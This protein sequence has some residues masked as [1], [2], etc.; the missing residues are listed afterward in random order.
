MKHPR[1][2][3]WAFTLV[4]V[5]VIVAVVSILSTV[6]YV[7]ITG[8]REGSAASKLDQDVAVLNNAI[9]AYLASGGN[10]DNVTTAA[11][12]LA[13]LKTRATA[14]SA[15]QTLGATGSFVDPRI[16]PVWQDAAEA[17][18]PVLRAY[19]TASPTPRFY[20]SAAAGAAGIKQFALD[21]A[22]AAG[23]P[24]T[25]TRD[26]TLAQ[27]TVSGW[28]WAYED[29]AAPEQ[30]PAAVPVAEDH[31]TVLNPGTALVTLDPPVISPAAGSRTI[32]EY[33]LTL[34]ISNPNDAGS[35]VIYY[36]LGSGP[37]VLFSA[38]FT[39]GPTQVTAVCVSLD[40]SRYADSAPASAT[41]DVTPVQLALQVSAPASLTYAQAGG[42]MIGEAIQS[43]APATINLVTA[44]PSAYLS[45]ANFQ[46][47]YTTDGSDP[48]TSGTAVTGSPFSG[49]FAPVP[50]NIALS[51]TA[52]W[53]GSSSLTLR[54]A[55]RSL[56]ADYFTSSGV[57]EATVS[58][59]PVALPAPT[60]SPTNQ[61]VTATVTVVIS[62]P[63]TG[64]ATNLVI[65]YT[66]NGVS[67]TVTNS[68]VYGGPF[69]FTAFT[70]NEER[71]AMA[72]SFPPSGFL[73]NWFTASGPA[74]RTYV[75]AASIGGF[76]SGAL[77][78]SATLNSTFNGNITIAYPTNGAVADITYNQNA[79]INGSLYVPGTPRVAQ[80][81]PYIPQWTTTNDSQFANRIYGIVEGQSPSPRVVDLTG[82]TL[83]TNY[84]ITFNN[85]SY[86]TGKIFRRIERY[87]L[88][89]LDVSTFPPKT[90]SASLSLNGPVSAP[91]NPANV[92][93]VTL[94]TTAVGSVPLL[95]GTYGNM[96]A[97]NNSKFVLGNAAD[98]DTPVVYNF[99]SLTLNSGADLVIVGKVIL[100][101]KGGFNLSNGAVVG[102]INNPDWLQI[103]VW[104]ANVNVASGSS[105]YGRIF[106][107]NNTIAFNN[108]SVLNGSVSAK[109][110]ELNSTSIVF[111]L[112][113]PTSPDG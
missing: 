69:S 46:I 68:F 93:N 75:G 14:Q 80:N 109:T 5:L 22:A 63:T 110:L 47:L 99:D 70:A 38:P 26:Q 39:I 65:R 84:V 94:N 67:P 88:S 100:N 36:R 78:G 8:V 6:G 64:P 76:P 16:T 108:G 52:N 55:A 43:P 104:S 28:I 32:L 107:P 9:D 21:E 106:A 49:T 57:S 41:Y 13:K 12:A 50:I 2:S 40:K 59:A 90:S 103:N 86:L 81:S 113:P 54:A 33:P 15:A 111:S 30:G 23:A 34:S 74:S 11:G 10:M 102:D 51:N 53:G 25:E 45:S 20:T 87:S 48:L 96:T 105:V 60:I 97:N 42:S 7:A 61:T 44:V 73:T 112:A 62:N 17:A 92:A 1:Q 31:Q 3:G 85:N 58:A 77:V 83:P 29:R 18:T 101:L 35:S 71:V 98:P 37:Y 56:N 4:E 79:V 91:L 66:T 89:P 27:N 82:P 24:A 95:P 19:F 72:S